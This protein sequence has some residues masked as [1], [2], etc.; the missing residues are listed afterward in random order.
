VS[1]EVFPLWEQPSAGYY[2][3]HDLLEGIDTQAFSCQD[4]ITAS[5]ATRFSSASIFI[6]LFLVVISWR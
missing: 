5:L 6:F 2:P 4:E 3:R 1:R